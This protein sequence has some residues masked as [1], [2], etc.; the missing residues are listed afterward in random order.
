MVERLLLRIKG[1]E[2]RLAGVPENMGAM[3][4]ELRKLRLE[5][6]KLDHIDCELVEGEPMEACGDWAAT[7]AYTLRRLTR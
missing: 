7:P 3:L 5:E 4:E 6:E 2:A 1:L